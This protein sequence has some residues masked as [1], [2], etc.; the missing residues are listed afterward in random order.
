[1]KITILLLL[2]PVLLCAQNGLEGLWEGTITKRGL[3]Q[4]DGYRFEL[5]L[6]VEDGVIEGISSIYIRQDSVIKQQLRG[7][8]Y[9][10]RSIGLQE[11]DSKQYKKAAKRTDK[12][13]A[14]F[15]R[16]YQFI[17]HR[18]LYESKIDGYWQ[19]ITPK[20]LSDQRKRGRVFLVRR[21]SKA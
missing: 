3:P 14:S 7:K 4:K 2:F 15:L 20:P 19:E 21:S 6:T 16:K 10:D 13:A 1:M 12:P 17:F 8:M 9:Q 18:G 5:Y 11:V